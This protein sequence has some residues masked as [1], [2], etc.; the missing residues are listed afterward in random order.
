MKHACFLLL[1]GFLGLN[2]LVSTNLIGGWGQWYSDNM[3]YRRQTEAL[4]HGS[5]ALSNNPRQISWDLAWGA[6]GVQQVWGLGV[7][8]WQVPFELTARLFGQPAFPDRLIFGV[9]VV[10]TG[11][12]L[13][14]VF[15]SQPRSSQ[16]T[17]TI[18]RDPG[19]CLAVPLLLFFPP[20]VT[21]CRTRFY[22]YEEV[23]AYGYLAGTDLLA[24]TISFTR[25]P[26]RSKY[27]CLNL[28][29]G[30]ISFVRPTLIV[31]GIAAVLIAAF[32]SRRLRWTWLRSFSGIC[33]FFLGVLALLI[34][35][36]VRFDSAKE[37]GHQLNLN[38]IDQMR[39]ASRFDHP[40]RLEPLGPAFRELFG[41]LFLARSD[42]NATD[43]YRADFF[44][45]QSATL[46]WR[47]FYFTTFDLS[48]LLIAGVTCI[49][50]AWSFWQKRNR[51]GLTGSEVDA[52]VV[53]AWSLLAIMPLWLFYLWCPFIASRYLLDFAPGLAGL[54]LAGIFAFSELLQRSQNFG[55]V[56]RSAICCICLFW[57]GSEIHTA[58]VVLG[59]P[60]SHTLAEIVT[61]QA[62]TTEAPPELPNSYE[63]G[64]DLGKYGITFNG[65]GWNPDTGE[66]AAAIAFFIRDPT[67]L[68]I[69]VAPANEI[70]LAPVE[71]SSIKAKIGLETLNL[72]SNVKS[73]FG[74][75]LV[76]DG[77]SSKVYQNGVQ[78]AFLAFARTDELGMAKSKFL[79]RRISWRPENQSL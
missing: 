41:G 79:V 75:I 18:L 34:T 15:W 64:V 11:Y 36:W 42:L 39:F 28:L 6:G 51:A 52:R 50:V 57:L 21:L 4:L 78:V 20:F 61:W 72:R 70:Q 2:L 44:A 65:I 27:F 60:Q 9:A 32:Q 46:R 13:M 66:A 71:Y 49:L 22:V 77:P 5:M 53:T 19:A 62:K 55:R 67:L 26:T 10:A 48:Y 40:Y 12:F 43:W 47:E 69:E 38:A 16:A 56:S 63:L 24:M 76:F 33:L 54:C 8:L 68:E 45:G 17:S 58:E 31:Y 37:F 1:A 74:R 7:P 73:E 23:Q 30:F 14:R 59:P 35:N 3:A 25:R 29:A